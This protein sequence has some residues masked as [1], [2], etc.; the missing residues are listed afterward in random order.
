MT[1]HRSCVS[2]W[3]GRSRDSARSAREHLIE[4]SEHPGPRLAVP[5][6]ERVIRKAGMRQAQE[7]A[8]LAAPSGVELDGDHGLSSMCPAGGHPGELDQRIA[9]EAQEAPVV[10]VALLR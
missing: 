2:M 6:T 1:P 9:L 3:S 5:L 4:M 8:H 7:R 10:R